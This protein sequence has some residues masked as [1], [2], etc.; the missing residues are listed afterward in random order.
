MKKKI[1][2]YIQVPFMD[3]NLEIINL[4]KGDFDIHVLIELPQTMLHA[5]IFDL[6]ID[7]NEYEPLTSFW[8]VAKKWGLDYLGEYFRGCGSVHFVIYKPGSKMGLITT[9]H[10]VLKFINKQKF[11]Y[12]QF[13]DFSAR[14]AFLLPFLR[15]NKRLV[16]SI[17]DPTPHGGEF[18]WKRSIIRKLFYGKAVAYITYSAYSKA[19]LKKNLNTERNIVNLKL[20][21]Y[22]VFRKFMKPSP[23]VDK[24]DGFIAF[25]GRLS[26]YKGIDLLLD[27]IPSVLE[28]F[29]DQKFMIAGRPAFGYTTD[30]GKVANMVNAVSVM[31]R[32]LSNEEIVDV[33]S[34]S[35]LIVCPYLEATQSGIVMTAYALGCP[36]LVTNT[37]G[38]AE[39]VT[40]YQTGLVA[41]EITSPAIAGKILEFL[42]QN[43]YQDMHDQITSG[44]LIGDIKLSNLKDLNDVYI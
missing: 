42:E 6:N 3:I 7:L 44:H 38:L 2:L 28:K 39:S 19:Q 20:L 9:T 17:H 4:I 43:L 25:V 13:D 10:K 23:E 18:E 29:P 36:V 41:A 32:H 33:I 35:T 22:T 24:R 30:H 21:P 12:L 5:N 26:K 1:L 8:T 16:L 14:Q 31:E 34:R 27:A 15:L 37:G 11:D 40:D